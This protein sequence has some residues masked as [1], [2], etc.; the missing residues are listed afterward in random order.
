MP[1]TGD[2]GQSSIKKGPHHPR[3]PVDWTGAFAALPPESPSVDGWQHLQARLA[4][5]VVPTRARR[6]WPLWLASAAALAL[7]IAIPLRMQSIDT[8]SAHTATVTGPSVTTPSP[9]PVTTL[10]VTDVGVEV[11]S[12]EIVPDP[13]QDRSTA[14]LASLSVPTP[15]PSDTARVRKPH[16]DRY[17]EPSQQPIRTAAEPA[18]IPHIASTG[19]IDAP[20]TGIDQDSLDALY[21]QS[22][23]LEGLL[24]LARDDR[25]STGTAAALIDTLTSRMASIDAALARPDADLQDKSALWMARVDTL[26]SLVGIE[27]T[28]RLYA[29]RGLQFDPALVS[30]D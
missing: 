7:V 28:Q 29:A 16:R 23:Q 5:A 13:I 18:G 10:P 17:V 26:Q 24:A 2:F 11:A 14:T 15:T 25:V 22:A 20:A 12:V 19:M 21:A 27:S 3:P 4:T 6:R 1:D 30:I 8:T 9:E